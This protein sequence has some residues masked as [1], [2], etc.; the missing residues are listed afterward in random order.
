ML[1][2]RWNEASVVVRILRTARGNHRGEDGDRDDAG[3]HQRA[4]DEIALRQRIN[5]GGALERASGASC[6]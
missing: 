3:D 1:P 2:G 5:L 4:E 6:P